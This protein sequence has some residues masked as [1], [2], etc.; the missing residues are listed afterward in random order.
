MA[1]MSYIEALKVW[2]A[3]STQQWCNP[4][5]GT[6]QHAAVMRIMRGESAVYNEV[7]KIEKKKPKKDKKSMNV[8][9]K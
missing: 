7:H 2:N 3:K 5:K 4:R 9:L 1:K 6:P 8:D